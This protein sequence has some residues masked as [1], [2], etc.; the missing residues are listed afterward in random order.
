MAWLIT[1]S[2]FHPDQHPVSQAV[3]MLPLYLLEHVAKEMSF[4][5]IP[6]FAYEFQFSLTTLALNLLSLLSGLYFIDQ[7]SKILIIPTRRSDWVYFIFGTALFYFSFLQ[8][9]VIEVFAFPLLSY[10]LFVYIKIKNGQFLNSPVTL[11]IVTGF[12]IITKI[13]FWPACVI[14]GLSYLTSGLKRRALKELLLF[15]TSLAAIITFAFSNQHLKYNRFLF[16]LAPPLDAFLNFSIEN[17]S[18]NL[19]YGFFPHGGLFYANP[20]YFF[21]IIGF[22]LLQSHLKSTKMVGWSDIALH[23]VWFVFVFFGHMF[24][25]GY[26]VEDH[27]PGRI[28]LAFLPFLL[29][30]FI[31]FRN[32]FCKR[33]PQ[34]SNIFFLLCCFWHLLITFFYLVQI[35]GSSFRYATSMVPS[36]YVFS[37]LLPKYYHRIAENASGVAA[38]ILQIFIFSFFIAFLLFAFR[39]PFLRF[40][41]ARTLITLAGLTFGVMSIL[42][43]YFAPLNADELIRQDYFKKMA[44]G[45]GIELFQIDYTLQNINTLRTRCSPT[46]CAELDEGIKRYYSKV[47]TQILRSSPELDDAVLKNSSNFSFW[48]KIEEEKSRLDKN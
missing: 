19:F 22:L 38:H 35:Q 5:T 40:T 42:N 7:I 30:G 43:F 34:V 17:F 41:M 25:S 27:L 32:L 23:L 4:T 11:G 26:I 12:L 16:D 10:L 36:W 31:Y 47:A 44:V 13:T 24:L 3:F 20:I 37:E 48:I 15:G 2:Y 46:I 18:R 33:H 8:T 39:R 29:L 28:H 45:N 9:T 14:F 21:G 6:V 1:P